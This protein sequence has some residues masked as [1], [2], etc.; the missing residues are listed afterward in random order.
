MQ[1][2]GLLE[3]AAD[4]AERHQ[5]APLRGQIAELEKPAVA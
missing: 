1:A 2:N 3:Q 5:L 4:L